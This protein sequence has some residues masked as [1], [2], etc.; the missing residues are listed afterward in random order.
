MFLG[1]S[2]DTWRLITS[3]AASIAPLLT[4]SVLIATL[5]MTKSLKRADVMNEFNRRFD[6]LV[7]FAHNIEMKALQ[8]SN[9]TGQQ[10][11]SEVD[12]LLIQY[13]RRYFN[14]QF[15]QFVAYRAGLVE[16][17]IFEYWMQSRAREFIS[18]TAA[19]AG[20]SYKDGWRIFDNNPSWVHHKFKDFMLKV[21][22]GEMEALAA[23]NELR[24]YWLN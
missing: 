22:K 20:M 11:L 3:I 6:A 9:K 19:V 4:V 7:E 1:L 10:D 24:H 13:Y 17:S 5:R 15:D 2:A 18:P 16:R 8:K 14:L 23:V 21:H 12:Q